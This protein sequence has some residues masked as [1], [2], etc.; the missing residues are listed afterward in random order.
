MNLTR[1]RILSA[2]RSRSMLFSVVAVAVITLSL[3]GGE[4][5]QASIGQVGPH[6]TWN[7]TV[8][9]QGFY[10]VNVVCAS[11][12]GFEVWTPRIEAV[13][14]RPSTIEMQHVGW[15]AHLYKYLNASGWTEQVA[16]GWHVTSSLGSYAAY[17][18]LPAKF[19]EHSLLG[20]YGKGWYVVAYDFVWF[21]SPV[22]VGGGLPAPRYVTGSDF[23]FK[24]DLYGEVSGVPAIGVNTRTGMC[25]MTN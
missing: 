24:G 8:D 22:P 13:N 19:G 11:G 9:G 25:Y 7:D 14:K 18:D 21:D 23:M 5:V 4:T 1:T 6:D 20:D 15:Q 17:D 16:T 3:G 12:Y 2:A 10:G